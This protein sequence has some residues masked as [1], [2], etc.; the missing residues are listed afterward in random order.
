MGVNTKFTMSI[1]KIVNIAFTHT[2]GKF[3]IYKMTQNPKRDNNA[4]TKLHFSMYR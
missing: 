1:C 4:Q 3:Q 2:P